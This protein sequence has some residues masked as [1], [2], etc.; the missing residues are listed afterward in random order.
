MRRIILVLRSRL[1]ISVLTG[2]AVW[3]Q[4]TVKDRA[5][6]ANIAHLDL[7]SAPIADLN[8]AF[9]RKV[10]SPP[11]NSP[12]SIS[13]ASPPTRLGKSAFLN[14]GGAPTRCSP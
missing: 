6:T 10:R 11:K 2:D 12:I 3:A 9:K 8:A 1:L 5:A 14:A 4:S 7:K 13:P